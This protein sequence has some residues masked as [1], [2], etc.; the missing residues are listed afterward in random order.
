LES[1][2][3][4]DFDE[5]MEAIYVDDEEGCEAITRQTMCSRGFLDFERM[6]SAIELN[7]PQTHRGREEAMSRVAAKLGSAA[8]NLATNPLVANRSQLLPALK[9]AGAELSAMPGAFPE[10]LVQVKGLGDK[11]LNLARL[12][13][14]SFCTI[15]IILTFA[16]AHLLFSWS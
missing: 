2:G 6:M 11:G 14:P 5:L 13:T 9:S 3:F 15:V 4:L 1:R 16:I 7:D 8:E 12:S 10:N